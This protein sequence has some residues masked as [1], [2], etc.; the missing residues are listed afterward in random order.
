MFHFRFALVFTWSCQF[1]AM[2]DAEEEREISNMTGEL[3]SLTVAK[4]SS[5]RVTNQARESWSVQKKSVEKNSRKHNRKKANEL[6]MSV[7][8]QEKMMKLVLGVLEHFYG[9]SFSSP[10]RLTI[11]SIKYWQRRCFHVMKQFSSASYFLTNR[12]HAMKQFLRSI[13]NRTTISF[14]SAHELWLVWDHLA[15][16]SHPRSC[17]QCFKNP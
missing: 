1:V 2:C 17:F 6:G 8:K 3:W 10:R 15:C 9:F 11:F 5:C 16:L 4:W 14:G 7:K 13:S 12:I